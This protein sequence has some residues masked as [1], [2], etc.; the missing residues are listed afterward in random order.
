[1]QR[2][3]QLP[4]SAPKKRCTETW[5]GSSARVPCQGSWLHL[6]LRKLAVHAGPLAA[7]HN[8][9]CSQ[10]VPPPFPLDSD[11]SELI[12]ATLAG[13]ADPLDALHNLARWIDSS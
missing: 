13:H 4:E 6:S 11:R 3:P 12:S 1:M 7:L 8:L 5:Q 9:A 2:C 10:T